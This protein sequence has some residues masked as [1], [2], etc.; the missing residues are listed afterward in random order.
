M[1][2]SV[3]VAAA[4]ATLLSAWVC[5]RAQRDAAF[6]RIAERE[7][8]LDAI[9]QLRDR[10]DPG[11]AGGLPLATCFGEHRLIWSRCGD[12]ALLTFAP[13]SSGPLAMGRPR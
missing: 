2:A 12:A 9:V 5:L 8:Q 6:A 7:A 13:A 10:G 4:I 11:A 3:A 1:R